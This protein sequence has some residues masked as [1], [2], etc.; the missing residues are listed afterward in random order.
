MLFCVFHFQVDFWLCATSGAGNEFVFVFCVSPSGRLCFCATSWEGIVI[1]FYF[2]SAVCL[3]QVLYFYCIFILFVF[4][5]YFIHI[6]YVFYLYLFVLF[7]G[8]PLIVC[9][10]WGTYCICIFIL[11]AS[12]SGGHLIVFNIWGW[13]CICIFCILFEL[14]WYLCMLPGGP[15]IVWH[16]WGRYCICIFFVF[17]VHHLPVDLQLCATSGPGTLFVILFCVCKL[18]ADFVSVHRLRQVL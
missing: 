13:Y 9:Y 3:G 15:F 11:C 16:I 5:T 14:F 4:Y 2:Y 10:N 17:C 18:Q 8:E 12:P 6:L 7:P 1:V